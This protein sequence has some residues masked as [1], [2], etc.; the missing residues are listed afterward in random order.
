MPLS[1]QCMHPLPILSAVDE[2]QPKYSA[3]TK[4]TDHA[5]GEYVLKVCDK[6]ALCP[7]ATQ[8]RQKWRESRRQSHHCGLG[9]MGEGSARGTLPVTVT[10]AANR[11][12]PSNSRLRFL[13]PAQIAVQWCTTGGL[14]LSNHPQPVNRCHSPRPISMNGLSVCDG[15]CPFKRLLS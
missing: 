4:Y 5:G 1:P 6:G 9:Q 2:T 10:G 12:L 13:S 15:V 8:V 11:R 14:Q 7:S 3:H